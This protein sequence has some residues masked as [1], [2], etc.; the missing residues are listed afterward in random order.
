MWN[1][2]P[3]SR[4]HGGQVT[5]MI[6]NDSAS[7]FGAIVQ[8][9]TAILL[10]AC[11]APA[12]AGTPLARHMQL[13]ATDGDQWVTPNPGYDPDQGGPKDFGLTF[14]VAPDGA[15]ATG[16]LA[17]ITA[18]GRRAIY[19]TLIAL[20]NPV[21]EK[22]VTQQIG[23]DGA[24]LY[25][26]VPLQPGAKQIIDMLHHKADG[27][28]SYSRHELLFDSGDRHS[29]LVHE[30]DGAGGWKQTQRW[31]WVRQDM[32]AQET[33]SKARS[34][35][36]DLAPVLAE[37]VGFWLEGSGRWRAPN[38]DYEPDGTAEQFYGMNFRT[39]PH[40]QHVVGEIV[41]IFADG[42]E[43]K[44]WSMYV[45]YNPVTQIVAQ[46]Q[47][48][49]SG[50]YFRGE[51]GKLDNGRHTQSGVIYL[52]NGQAKSVRDEIEIIDDKRYRSHVFERTA[53]GAWTKVR[54]W[55][56][57]RQPEAGSQD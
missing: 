44:D 8:W 2:R 15:H 28:L 5:L 21:T 45:T 4:P 48:G 33:S 27:S 39:G 20:Y 11:C 14:E 7:R 42:R 30:P 53:D 47:T 18:D 29:A 49:V 46:E 1:A 34:T 31:E 35:R 55:L 22:V 43:Q 3:S 23:W 25:G 24:L 6:S 13:M 26:E 38:P 56:W 17:G 50:I 51:L 12:M 52:P 10:F 41:S 19:W 40:G 37:H 57:T 36:S 54:E 32:P 16:Q 9:G